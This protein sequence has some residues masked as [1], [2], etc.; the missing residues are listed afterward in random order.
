MRLLLLNIYK[1]F[2][3]Q[4]VQK[5]RKP[6]L[7]IWHKRNHSHLFS[8]TQKTDFA[9]RLFFN[10]F[11]YVVLVLSC[12]SIS[13]DKLQ[14]FQLLHTILSIKVFKDCRLSHCMECVFLSNK[15]LFWNTFE[16]GIERKTKINGN[17]RHLNES[18]SEFE[19]YAIIPV[20]QVL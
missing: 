2:C 1:H 14:D 16:G 19:L 9:L 7:N 6:L 3:I 8:H 15:I 20:A 17:Y 10:P 11:Y 18:H 12:F 4:I 5:N 13:S